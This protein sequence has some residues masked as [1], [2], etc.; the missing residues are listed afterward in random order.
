MSNGA[1]ADVGR[2]QRRRHA[3]VRQRAGDQDRSTPRAAAHARQFG[4]VADQHGADVPPSA[5]AQQLDRLD[6]VIAPCH[7]RNAPANTASVSTGGRMNG[8]IAA[9]AGRNCSVSAPHSSTWMRSSG[10]PRG[11]W[12]VGRDDQIRHRAETLAPA[13]HRLEDDGA[14][15]QRLGRAG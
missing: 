8:G 3:V 13:A 10:M 15:E 5:R 2:G 4:A 14:I 11:G 6:E 1:H 7:D 12:R 9:G